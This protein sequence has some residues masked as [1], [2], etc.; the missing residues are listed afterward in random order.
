MHGYMRHKR[1]RLC[2]PSSRHCSVAE[3]YACQHPL[4]S[5]C[6]SHVCLCGC[7]A[8]CRCSHSS[9]FTHPVVWRWWPRDSAWDGGCCPVY[10]GK[11]NA[12]LFGNFSLFCPTNDAAVQPQ[13]HCPCTRF[14]SVPAEPVSAG[15][16]HESNRVLASP[17]KA[18]NLTCGSS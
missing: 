8:C 5:P 11:L 7:H 4:L 3:L 12:A 6:Q 13:S 16:S 1:Q 2:M 9:L 10:F 18:P 14:R 17:R 15:V